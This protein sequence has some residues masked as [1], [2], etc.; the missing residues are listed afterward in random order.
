MRTCEWARELIP[1][2]A[3]GTLSSD[4][5]AEVTAHLADCEACRRELAEILRVKRSVQ[6]ELQAYPRLPERAWNRVAAESLGRPVARLDVGSFLVGFS[7][8]ANV[9]R[10]GLPVYGDL[11]L[12]GR[13]IRLFNVEQEERA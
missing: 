10:G 2:L 13:K 12:L 8:G 6:D 1:W 11:K 9:R 5:S 4:E 7:L 3:N